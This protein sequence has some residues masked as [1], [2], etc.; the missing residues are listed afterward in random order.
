VVPDLRDQGVPV[1][2]ERREERLR[3]DALRL[4]VRLAVDRGRA[5]ADAARIERDD[6]E[7]LDQRMP[8]RARAED[9][10]V[11]DG[12]APGPPKL[13]K[14]APSRVPAAGTRATAMCPCGPFL[15]P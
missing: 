8:Q 11:V 9:L 5:L 13:K 2:V 6:V 10:Q 14:S 12:G 1:D 7:V 4:L 3:V 15:W